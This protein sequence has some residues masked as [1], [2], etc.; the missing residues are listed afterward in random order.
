MVIICKNYITEY[1]KEGVWTLPQETAKARLIKCMTLFLEYKG[2]LEE[3]KQKPSSEF[4][5]RE[6][7]FNLVRVLGSF[8]SFCGRLKRVSSGLFLYESLL[9][10]LHKFEK[11]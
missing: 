8:D 5:T 11:N 1:G 6:F 2:R 10:M 3:V 7:Q 9:L 4:G